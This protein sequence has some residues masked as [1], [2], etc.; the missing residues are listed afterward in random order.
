MRVEISKSSQPKK[1]WQ[2]VSE[3]RKIHFGQTGYQDFTQHK[4]PK[5][6]LNYLSRHGSKDWSKSNLMS[7]AFMSRWLLWEKPSLSAAIANL[8][9][10]YSDVNFVLR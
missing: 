8:N 3:T 10:K 7:P 1:K 4:D 2:A 9:E 6:R 5:R